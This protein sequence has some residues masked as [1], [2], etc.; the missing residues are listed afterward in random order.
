[1]DKNTKAKSTQ[2]MVPIKEIRDGVVILADGTMRI[3]LL[4][5][6]INFALKSYDEQTAILLQYQNF[7]NSIDFPLQIFV[8]SRELDIRPYISTLEERLKEQT[9][10]ILK[11]QV[12]EYIQFVKNFVEETD[13]MT[14]K[15]F[16]V[17]PYDPPFIG[18]I[19]GGLWPFSKKNTDAEKT[20]MSF[21]EN[22]SQLEQRVS[23]VR[24]GLSSLGVRLIPLGTEELI[25]LYFKLFNPGERD[26]P[27]INQ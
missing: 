12:K 25:E 3:V 21:Q 27:Q 2:D 22:K 11:I 4:A 19:K 17:V 24:Q 6:S 15:F 8:N 18:S 7:L 26:V 20:E 9:V 14:K 13:I 23:V 1:M 16:I 5:S 10:E